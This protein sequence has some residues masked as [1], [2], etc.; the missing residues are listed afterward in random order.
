LAG[1]KKL[2]LKDLKDQ[3]LILMKSGHGF[4][5]IVLDA[6][7][8]AGVEPKV[9]H[10]SGEIET[11]QALVEAGLGLSLVPKMVRRQGPAYAEIAP[12]TPSRSLHLAWRQDSGL[13]PAA[14]ALKSAAFRSLK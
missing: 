10:E 9:V 5:K 1:R 13:S 4:R 11:V 8:R 3:P 12:P 6:L 2:A 7:A 14:E